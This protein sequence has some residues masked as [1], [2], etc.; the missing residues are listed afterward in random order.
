MSRAHET[1]GG[2]SR[3][4]HPDAAPPD[5]TGT[6]APGERAAP[7]PPPATGARTAP[8]ATA[9]GPASAPR[10]AGVE[11]LAVHLTALSDAELASLLAARPDLIAPP[12]PSLTSLAARAGARPSVERA[13]ADLDAPAL[14]AARAVLVMGSRDP[15]AL[16]AALGADEEAVAARLEQLTRL[17]LLTAAGPVV[18]LVEALR[19]APAAA[20]APAPGS[21]A[22]PAPASGAGAPGAAGPASAVGASLASAIDAGPASATGADT[23][24][25]LPAPSRAPD[26]A[27]LDVQDAAA[28]ADQCARAA[29]ELVRLTSA[30]LAEWG[31]EGAPILRS[32][33]V[34]AR[35][36]THTTQALDLTVMMLLRK[37]SRKENPQG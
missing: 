9:P 34:G 20:S 16:A 36:L 26:P 4:G 37:K 2:P 21:G 28:V 10:T 13:L 6:R 23:G 5:V 22:S 31:R 30:L 15:A 19:P 8:D 14:D 3:T 11:E 33:G 27:E 1:T 7:A 29:E 17:C 32:S 25:A 12:S 24:P 35:A 18:G